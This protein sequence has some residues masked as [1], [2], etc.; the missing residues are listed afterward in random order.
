MKWAIGGYREEELDYKRRIPKC[1][2]P[3][4]IHGSCIILLSSRT[5]PLSYNFESLYNYLNSFFFIKN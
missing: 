2:G 4:L 3:I 5:L 1:L